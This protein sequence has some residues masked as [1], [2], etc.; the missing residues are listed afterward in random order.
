MTNTY[1]QLLY[2]IVFSTKN[3]QPALDSTH[4]QD[5]FKYIWGIHQNLNCHLYRIG[6][7]EDHLHILTHMPTTLCIADYVREVKTG[8]SLWIK[9]QQFFPVFTGWQDGYGAFTASFREKDEL[10]EYIKGQEEHH[11][12]ESYIDEYRRLLREAGIVFEEK[13]LV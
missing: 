6:G 4:R 1:T 9:E 2:H 5:L 8:S 7:V 11:R 12:R 3:R 10:I 13:Y